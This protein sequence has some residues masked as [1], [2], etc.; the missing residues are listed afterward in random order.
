MKHHPKRTTAKNGQ[1]MV[2]FVIAIF[3]IVILITGITE[4]IGFAGKR[5]EIFADVRGKAGKHALEDSVD[6]LETPDI[7]QIPTVETSPSALSR[8]FTHEKDEE[9]ITLSKSMKEWVFGGKLSELTVRG[10]V[11]MPSMKIGGVEE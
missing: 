8:G 11:W 5:G 9:K 3:A 2:E 1:A 6:D 4:F 7:T 10:E